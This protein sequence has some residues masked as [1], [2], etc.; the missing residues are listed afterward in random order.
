MS[1]FTS[2]NLTSKADGQAATV[3][4]T[5]DGSGNPGDGLYRLVLTATDSAGL[6]DHRPG[7][8]AAGRGAAQRRRRCAP[9]PLPRFSVSWSGQ[10][11]GSGLRD[12]DV[13]YQV[14]GGEWTGWYTHT[15]QTG[16]DFNGQMGHSYTF[17]VQATDQVSNTAVAQ[18]QPVV[19]SGVTKYYYLGDGRVAMRRGDVV[20]F[21]HTDH[22]SEISGQAWG[23]LL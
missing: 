15:S 16:A 6:W 1:G 12:Y 7:D 11:A 2:F 4:W 21:I 23:P 5:W 18:S 3:S 14:D 9:G 8:G 13:A 22:P 19:V 20:Y 10:D 17:R